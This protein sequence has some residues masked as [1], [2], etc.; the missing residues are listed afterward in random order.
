MPDPRKK[1]VREKAR[2]I[3]QAMVDG[4]FATVVRLTHPKV[5][6]MAGGSDRMVS[7]L[8][9]G[10]QKMKSNGVAVTGVKVGSPSGFQAAGADLFAIIP[11]AMELT[12]PGGKLT[13]KSFVVG[14]SPDTGAT[15]F[16]ADGNGMTADKVK[17]VFPHFPDSLPLPAQQP[18]VF[19]AE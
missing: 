16:F 3:S 2:E 15:W 1:R 4:N 7:L 8:Q 18:A 5:V 10:M 12:V 13:Q 17:T 11:T 6:E 19:K 9:S 14:V